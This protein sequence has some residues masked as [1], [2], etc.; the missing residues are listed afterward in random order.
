MN[1][2]GSVAKVFECIT[3]FMMTQMTAKA[4]IKKR[5]QVA[6]DALYQEFLQLHDLGVFHGQHT[7]KLTKGQK[8]GA[9]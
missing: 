6:I 3:G 9:L 7:D 4:R 1:V 5:G 2:H 8:R